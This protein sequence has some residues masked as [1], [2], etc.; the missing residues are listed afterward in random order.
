MNLETIMNLVQIVASA[1]CLAVAVAVLR[2]DE[3]GKK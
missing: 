3:R 1:I 2:A